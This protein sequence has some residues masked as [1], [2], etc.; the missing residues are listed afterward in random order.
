MHLRGSSPLARGLR[1]AGTVGWCSPGI[2]PARAGFTTRC[3]RRRRAAGDHPRSRGV[4][5]LLPSG[6]FPYSGS[7]PLARGLLHVAGP[8]GRRFRIIP[9]RAGFT[10]LTLAL[11]P[12][13]WDH[14][15]SRG[16]YGAGALVVSGFMG[17]SPLARGLREGAAIGL[18]C[19]GIIPA[20]AGFTEESSCAAHQHW[21][22]PRSRGVYPRS[23]RAASSSGG[24]SPLARG[25]PPPP[26][27]THLRDRIIPAR[28]GFTLLSCHRAPASADHP[29][30]R[31]VYE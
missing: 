14:P 15:R 23:G 24:S 7:S 2:I 3:A 31:G 22:H 26:T 20:R 13:M 1:V 10:K 28:A 11:S 29:R 25:L 18:G 8:L 19:G 5:T 30:S 6:S 17:S 16:V 9:A 21:D 12:Y 4:Y 27:P